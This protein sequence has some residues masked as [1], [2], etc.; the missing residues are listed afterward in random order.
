MSGLKG[1]IVLF[2]EFED[3]LSSLN[4][5]TYQQD[6][7]WNLIRFSGKQFSGGSFFAVTPEFVEKSKS[8][9][10]RK[11]VFNF[12]YSSFD[13]LPSFSMSPLE[14]QELEELALKIM[15][16]HGTAFSWNPNSHISNTE[17]KAFIKKSAGTPVQD[18]TRKT[19]TDTVAFLDDRFY[20]MP[21]SL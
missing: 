12:D 18:R 9:L 2:D 14:V 4:N 16:V 11:G 3:I 19:I 15:R 21:E 13:N 20:Q 1:F 17:L 10:L 6:A 7:F 5:I 8:L